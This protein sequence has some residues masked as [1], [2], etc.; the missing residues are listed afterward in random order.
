MD[1][2]I[3][4]LESIL[5]EP[6]VIDIPIINLPMIDDD[7]WQELARRNAVDNYRKEFGREPESIDEAVKWQRNK[8]CRER[9]YQ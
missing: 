2:V 4:N 9:N 3:N 6:Y 5:N 7:V 8:A 1:A